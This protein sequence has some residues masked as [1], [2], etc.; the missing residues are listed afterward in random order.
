V[1]L[2]LDAGFSPASGRVFGAPGEQPAFTNSF[3]F[4]EGCLKSNTIFH[5]FLLK[6]SPL[7]STGKASIAFLWP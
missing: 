4:T 6:Q 5:D 1:E 7:P 3:N 2:D